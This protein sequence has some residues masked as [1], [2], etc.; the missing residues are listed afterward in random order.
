M[1]P[2]ITCRIC[3]G[4]TRRS[5]PGS[6]ADHRPHTLAP[7]FHRPAAHGPLYRCLECGTVQPPSLP[8][9]GELVA[10]YREMDD[11][12]GTLR[13]AAELLADEG[14]LLVVT[15]TPSSPV[16]RLAGG[17]WW[18]Y[19]PAHRC[20]LPR[21]TL[22]ELIS[23]IGLL[24]ESDRALERSFSARYWVAGLAERSGPLQAPLA[25]LADRLPRRL[26]LS[27]TLG[28]E[29]VVLARKRSVRKPARP[30]V[31][32][33]GGEQRVHIVLPAY[34]AA[35]TV[36]AVAGALPLAAADRALLVDD[37]SPDGTVEAALAAGL[38]VLVHPQNRGYGANQK[39]CYVRA[40]LDGADVVVMV[41]A[42]NQYDPSLVQAMVAPIL[43]GRADVV[44][45]SRLLEDEAIAG[46]RPP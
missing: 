24:L 42:D 34:R 10:L 21:R 45:G 35:R 32:D 40:A 44:I 29:R 5:R 23:A 17:R 18:G 6:G 14:T 37:A 3:G 11:P 30:L 26:R 4:S 1:V 38:E 27:L 13:G 43:E 7:T 25:A 39:S 31:E 36:G 22:R 33:R 8:S 9:A 12:R 41:H 20:L 16:A 15:P 46:G 28:D 2:P 19:L